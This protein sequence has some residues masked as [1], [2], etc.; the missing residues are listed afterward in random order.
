MLSSGVRARTGSRVAHGNRPSKARDN[1]TR[2]NRM[3]TLW[4][5]TLCLLT[6][7]CLVLPGPA[8]A[9]S[10]LIAEARPHAL[11][12]APGG[13]I[14]AAAAAAPSV[15][16]TR[17]ASQPT[18]LRTAPRHTAAPAAPASASQ[19]KP[20]MRGPRT[21]ARPPRHAGL[22]RRQHRGRAPPR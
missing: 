20:R 22:R 8:P 15:T 7:L 6:V 3:H 4:V 11:T 18:T 2:D 13:E 9:A 5:I 1:A 21:G 14:P 19:R 16:S 17:A 12:L 10:G